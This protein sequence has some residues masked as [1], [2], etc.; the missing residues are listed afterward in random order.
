MSKCEFDSQASP[1]KDYSRGRR[2]APGSAPRIQ[3]PFWNSHRLMFTCKHQAMGVPKRKL[4]IRFL[5][6]HQYQVFHVLHITNMTTEITIL[7]AP[8][9]KPHC[10]AAK[11][12]DHL[13]FQCQRTD[14]ADPNKVYC[15]SQRTLLRILNAFTADPEMPSS[16]SSLLPILNRFTRI[17]RFVC[18][19]QCVVPGC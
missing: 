2:S 8:N 12:S 9:R 14:P 17:R 4:L 7:L 6:R 5:M 18:T 13:P 10:W 15:Q 3:F 11:I 1:W 16:F 19:A